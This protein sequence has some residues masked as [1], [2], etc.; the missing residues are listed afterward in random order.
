MNE[1]ACCIPALA[2]LLRHIPGA[3]TIL[4][5]AVEI[6]VAAKLRFGSR[7]DKL[8]LAYRHRRPFWNWVFA[9]SG[10]MMAF[11]KMDPDLQALAKRSK[12]G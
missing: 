1:R 5:P 12:G 4:L 7:L 8:W 2:V 6:V 11:D 3:K 9:K 10:Q